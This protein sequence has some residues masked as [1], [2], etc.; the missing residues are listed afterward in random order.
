MSIGERS[1]ECYKKLKGVGANGVLFRFET[2]NP[3]LYG[4]LHPQN[5]PK[6]GLQNRL[7]LL[8][9]LKE[10]GYYISSG[11][12]IGLPGQ[13]ANDL[14]EDVLLMKKLG[15]GMISMGPFIP[16]DNTPLSK[17]H[18][19]NLELSLK[20]MAVCRLMMKSV[21]IPVTTA[22]ETIDP[23]NARRIGLGCGA[24]SLMFNLTP[25]KFRE[26]Y[27]IYKNKYYGRD[28]NLEEFALYRGDG[29]WEMLEQEFRNYL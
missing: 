11:P 4:R 16:A 10:M 18:S 25:S 26:D 28:K 8:K 15:I 3:E 21:R 13:T 2:S 14:A 17:K 24:N 5:T 29:G 7:N 22:M 19:G 20:M 6:N 27:A 12:I 23:K 9:E 1:C